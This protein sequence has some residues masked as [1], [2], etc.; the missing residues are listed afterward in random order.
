[1]AG[2]TGAN[3]IFD[4]ARVWAAAGLVAS[5]G[6]AILGA[7]L[8]WV[9]I[10]DVPPNPQT[11]QAEKEVSE[12]AVPFNG[13]EEGDGWIV[14]VFGVLLILLAVVL[15]LRRRGFIAGL[16]LLSAVVIGAIGI[17]DYRAIGDPNSELV[18]EMELVGNPDPGV[19][20]M[21]V[22]ASGI[23][24]LV[25]AVVGLISTPKAQEAS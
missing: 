20:I 19:G 6:A 25:A 22:A 13:V 12:G 5:G 10:T 1:M 15:L 21:L 8:D 16:A 23:I 7:V 24:G 18:R 9:T 2:L 3:D 14:I 4:R 17:S 11:P